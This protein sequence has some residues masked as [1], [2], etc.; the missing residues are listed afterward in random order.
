MQ[1][2]ISLYVADRIKMSIH[3]VFYQMEEEQDLFTLQL[4]DG[5]YYWDIIRTE[6]FAGLNAAFKRST[7]YPKSE[8]KLS[9]ISL[10][11][12]IIVFLDP[13]NFIT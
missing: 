2:Q 6:L 4:A 10:E 11:T 5:T 9:I 7:A 1:A 13:S 3:D 8:Y 12:P